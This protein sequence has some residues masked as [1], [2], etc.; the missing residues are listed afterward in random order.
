MIDDTP[1]IIVDNQKL[2]PIGRAPRPGPATDRR[3]RQEER[4]FGVIDRV[5]ISREARE[6]SMQQPAQPKASSPTLEGLSINPHTA[7]T[8]RLTY[9]Q[10]KLR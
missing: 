2:S 9:S 8:V 6:K 1:F 7:T 5:T 3:T 4:P 10:K